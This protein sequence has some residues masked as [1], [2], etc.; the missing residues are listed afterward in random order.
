MEIRKTQLQPDQ[1]FHIYNRGINGSPVF[2]EEKNYRYFLQQYTKYVFPFVQTYAYCLLENHYHLLIKV[3]SEESLDL[4]LKKYPN[5]PFSWYVSN[6]FSS[7]LQSYTRAVNK[8]YDRTGPLFE[9]P[10]K[11]IQVTN[12]SYFSA[13]ITYIHRNPEKHGIVHDFRKYAHS[14]YHTHLGNGETKL[15]RSEVLEWFGDEKSY[16]KFHESQSSK[17]HKEWML[18]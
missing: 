13:L 6:A 16:S 12:D 17:I 4:H 7:F 11:R 3:R 5:K 9:K 14:S 18:E 10:F 2:F 8:M 15:E 1:F